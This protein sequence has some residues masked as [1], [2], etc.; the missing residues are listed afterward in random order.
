M[1][2]GMRTYTP[3]A[4][5]MKMPIIEYLRYEYMLLREI[6]QAEKEREERQS[7]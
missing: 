1:N 4:I 2:V 5:L 3:Y 7:R 6:E